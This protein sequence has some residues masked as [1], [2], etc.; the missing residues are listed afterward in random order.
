MPFTADQLFQTFHVGLGHVLPCQIS[1]VLNVV[2]GSRLNTGV[3]NIKGKNYF[4]D[5]FIQIIS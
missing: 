3:R 5:S 4:S 2:G 1:R